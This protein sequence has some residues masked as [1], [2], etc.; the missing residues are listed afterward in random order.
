MTDWEHHP[1]TPVAK[2][3]MTRSDKWKRRPAVLKYRAFC[4]EIR[5]RRVSLPDPGAHVVFHVPMPASW[6]RKKREAHRDQAHTQRPDVDNF[7]KAILDALYG[8]DSHIWDV[9]ATKVWADRGGISIR[10]MDAFEWFM[11]PFVERDVCG[12]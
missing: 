10:A 12:A 6:S 2:P 4:D 9:R 7:T 1:I 11:H 8:D 3:R 5:A